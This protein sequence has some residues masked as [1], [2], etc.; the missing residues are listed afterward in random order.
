MTTLPL[1]VVHAGTCMFVM[2]VY[3]T[4]FFCFLFWKVLKESFTVFR[5]HKKKHIFNTYAFT[6]AIG[7]RRGYTIAFPS[8]FNLFMKIHKCV[9]FFF[10]ETHPKHLH[11]SPSCDCRWK[12]I[13]NTFAFAI[14]VWFICWETHT[15]SCIIYIHSG[16]TRA[17]L[18]FYWL[19]KRRHMRVPLFSGLFYWIYSRVSRCSFSHPPT[20]GQ[21]VF[22]PGNT[23]SVICSGHETLFQLSKRSKLLAIKKNCKIWNPAMSLSARQRFLVLPCF[24]GF[25]ASLGQKKNATIKNIILDNQKPLSLLIFLYLFL[26]YVLSHVISS[27]LL[28]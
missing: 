26:T 27:Y 25:S 1:A 3:S 8:I 20:L 23:A 9:L 19:M 17:Y 5:K 16:N 11:I 6:N 22:S 10:V 13:F 24:Q 7:L 21:P 14:S 12:H 15:Y 28:I 4:T 18:C 2:H